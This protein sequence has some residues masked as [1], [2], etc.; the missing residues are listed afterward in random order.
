VS[1]GTVRFE[2][3][4][5]PH[6]A[7][8][9]ERVNV[10]WPD[11]APLAELPDLRELR[12]THTNPHRSPG[13]L[14]VDLGPLAGV[15]GL[16]VLVLRHYPI[17]DLDPLRH[18]GRL[19]V[20]DLSFAPLTDLGPLAGLGSLRDL[21]L[22]ATR[23]ASLAPLAGLTGLERLDVGHTPVSDVTPLHGLRALREVELDG[24]AVRH[25][26]LA[27]LAAALPD[28]TITPP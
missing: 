27:A 9:V 6:D 15:A 16:E 23:A 11:F 21:G 25:E 5:V 2:G 7:T 17:R 28:A 12:L 3:Q 18:L 26:A 19:R 8:V 22:R 20:L 24:T 10:A 4:D 14:P 13:S 1:T